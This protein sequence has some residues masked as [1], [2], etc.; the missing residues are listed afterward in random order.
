MSIRCRPQGRHF[1]FLQ[2][3]CASLHEIPG[4]FNLFKKK[5]GASV[6]L[7]DKIWMSE[8]AKWNGIVEEWKKNNSLIII[9]WF[10]HTLQQLQTVFSRVTTEP[11]N[12]QTAR[13]THAAHLQGKPVVFAEHYPVASRE[14]EVFHRLALTEVTIHSALDEPLFD[15]F[16]GAKI[17][18]M[19]KQL[20]LKEDQVTEHKLISGS[21]RNAQEKIA[22]KLTVEH[23]A[24]S[25]KEWMERNL[26]D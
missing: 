13:E 12:L 7:T 18:G 22:K 4:M 1:L 15:H 23:L 6:K 21:I 14:Q 26:A 3:L 24:N 19:M 8:T 9:C 11:V 2:Y 17:I 10:D 16:G 20:G 5:D 25:Q